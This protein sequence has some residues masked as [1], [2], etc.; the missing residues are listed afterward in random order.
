MSRYQPHDCDALPQVTLGPAGRDAPSP[1]GRQHSTAQ[2]GAS[3]YLSMERSQGGDSL[4]RAPSSL[5][6]A[7]APGYSQVSSPYV[8][9]PALPAT[10][11]SPG[12]ISIGAVAGGA[13]LV[14]QPNPSCQP[15]CR[16]GLGT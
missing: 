10:A 14:L 11:A 2:S 5:A 13:E 12:Y 1:M 8:A 4:H 6:P 16:V 9:A 7:P 15:Y 3:G